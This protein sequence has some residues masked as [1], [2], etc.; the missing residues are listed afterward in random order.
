M[1]KKLKEQAKEIKE[2]AEEKG[3]QS[4]FLFVTTFDRYLVQLEILDKLQGAIDEKEL[5][6]TKE[7]V[8]GRKNVYTSPAVKEY[9]S[10]TDSANKTVACLLKII[11]NFSAGDSGD[12]EDPLLAIMN[13]KDNDDNDEQ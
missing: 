8:K 1:D 4:N 13:G 9:N 3:V 5:L 7:Y 10:T 11:R 2:L 12:E 6:V